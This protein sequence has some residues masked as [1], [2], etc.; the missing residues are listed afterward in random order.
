MAAGTV[1]TSHAIR[2]GGNG[3][4]GRRDFIWQSGSPAVLNYE[5]RNVLGFSTDFAEDWSKTNWSTEA[6]WVNNVSALDQNS[7]TGLTK[8]NRY[9]LTVSVDRPTFINF[10]NPG[11]TFFINSQWFFS[12]TD[13]YE[14]SFLENGPVNVLFTLTAFTGYFQ[15]RL[16]PMITSVYDFNSTSGAVLPSIS[17]R[18]T[19]RLSAEFGVNYFYGGFDAKDPAINPIGPQNRAGENRQNEF[20]ENGLSAIRD[21]DELWFRFR[22]T[23]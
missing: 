12:Y 9:N 22:Y 21:H 13:G 8:V 16:Q 10:L 14:D 7:F 3:A 1:I 23:F 2:A 5:K 19:D 11:R 18:F 15:D 6:T 17:Y 4:F 20:W